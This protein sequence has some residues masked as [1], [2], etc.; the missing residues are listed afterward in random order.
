MSTAGRR[1]VCGPRCLSILRTGRAPANKRLREVVVC[2]QCS[3]QM[4]LPAGTKRRYCS[5]GC[6]ALAQRGTIAWNRKDRVTVHCRVCGIAVNE[7]PAR[8]AALIFCSRSC[9]AAHKRTVSGPAHH[10][11]KPKAQR[12][13]EWCGAAF[14]TKPAK[15]AAGEGRFCSRRCVGA[16]ATHIQGGRISSLETSVAAMLDALQEVYVQ[17]KQIGVWSVDFYIPRLNLVIECDGIYWHGLPKVK[18]RDRRKDE[19]LVKHGY[20]IL[21]LPEPLI[22]DGRAVASVKEALIA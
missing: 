5:R 2:A 19:W 6:H 20:R 12:V 13:C 17:Q 3:K 7:T 14:E 4:I 8:A 11:W 10:L 22:R 1:K 16:W 18:I 15:V 21:R 9:D